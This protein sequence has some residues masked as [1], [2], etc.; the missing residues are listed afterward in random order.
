MP[1][2]HMTLCRDVR[3][4]NLFVKR[5]GLSIDNVKFSTGKTKREFHWAGADFG[6]NLQDAY[7]WIGLQRDE[8]W[9]SAASFLGGSAC[10][11]YPGTT[12]CETHEYVANV[13]T[14]QE[15]L[16]NILA[17]NRIMSPVATINELLPMITRSFRRIFL[18]D[19]KMFQKARNTKTAGK[20]EHFR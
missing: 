8:R 12:A 13:Y 15:M 5:S 10:T 14:P 3:K 16:L 1:R 17:W 7:L 19:K 18:V 11:Q 2:S 6:F 20:I 4:A 9:E